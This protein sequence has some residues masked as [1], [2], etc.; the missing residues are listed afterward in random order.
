MLG[1]PASMSSSEKAGVV[2]NQGGQDHCR[3]I[4]IDDFLLLKKYSP[5]GIL[6]MNEEVEIFRF[7]CIIH[8]AINIP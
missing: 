3:S 8:L 5:E 6:I 7:M 1:K 4:S 2:L